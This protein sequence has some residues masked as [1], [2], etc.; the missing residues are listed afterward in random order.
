[1]ETT[2]Q[3]QQSS[4]QNTIEYLHT[5]EKIINID[6]FINT[7]LTEANTS[8]EIKHLLIK[9][10]TEIQII[11]ECDD[12]TNFKPISNIKLLTLNLHGSR[13][14]EIIESLINKPIQHLRLISCEID[15]NFSKII[16][17]I[18]E[19]V[20]L[21]TITFNKILSY[22]GQNIFDEMITAISKNVN[23]TKFIFTEIYPIE[24]KKVLEILDNAKNL[25]TIKMSIVQ[26]D[27]KELTKY[28]TNNEKLEAV[29]ITNASDHKDCGDDE[30]QLFEA[31][32]TSKITSL[33]LREFAM[34]EKIAGVIGTLLENNILEIL[35]IHRCTFY[36]GPFKRTN[37]K[38]VAGL[39]KNISLKYLEITCIS[40]VLQDKIVDALQNNTTITTLKLSRPYI[41]E[42]NIDAIKRLLENNVLESFTLDI[43]LYEENKY[44]YIY[45]KLMMG[46]EKN[47]SLKYLELMSFFSLKTMCKILKI[48]QYKSN[49]KDIL[50]KWNYND[51]PKINKFIDLIANNKS[52]ISIKNWG[53]YENE[54][55]KNL[56]AENMMENIECKKIKGGRTKK[57]YH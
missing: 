52:I 9:T 30:I 37:E 6:D 31:F 5:G 28:I 57:A 43:S 24:T 3:N 15:T 16:Q 55:I 10:Y 50:I 53:H 47:T 12:T 11:I 38:I 14:G 45:E 27:M 25:R 2:I 35:T 41:N 23:I 13:S 21:R 22:S 56:V 4:S 8:T 26:Q 7:N 32:L 33:K 1:M 19:N 54:T 18:T 46:L 51:E 29:D 39:E 48:L 17:L 20:T 40:H 42:I 34:R 36:G 49:L 44:I